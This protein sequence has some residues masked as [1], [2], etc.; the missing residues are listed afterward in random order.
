MA[1]KK[2]ADAGNAGK[3]PITKARP[4]DD[5]FPFHQDF[6]QQLVACLWRVPGAMAQHAEYF[7]P[8]YL[9]SATVRTL[10][11]AMVEHFKKYRQVPTRATL[12]EHIR[13]IHPKKNDDG[14]ERARNALEKKLDD[15]ASEPIDDYDY[16]DARIREFVRYVAVRNVLLDAKDDLIAMKYDPEL[17]KLVR[18]ALITGADQ[19]EA[20]HA[21][22][23]DAE[24]RVHAVT[25]PEHNPRIPTGLP[26]L[27]GLI[28]GG[29]QAGELGVLLALPK[30]F[31]SG[32]MLNFAY[33]GMQ[34]TVGI[35]V[36][37]ITLE[38]SEE[39]VGM[40]FDLR[41]ALKTK[42]EMMADPEGFLSILQQRMDVIVGDN[43]LF[44]KGFKTK[45]CTCDTIRAYLD[46]MYSQLGIKVGMLIVDYLDLLKPTRAR[47][48]TYIEDTDI[49][50][51]LRS[52]A[53]K[54]EYNIPIWTACIQYDQGVITNE[55]RIKIGRIGHRLRSSSA[56]L[57]ALSY[58]HA[59]RRNEWRQVTN[60]F[61]N[62]LNR[63]T[64][65]RIRTDADAP[66]YQL[67]QSRG[68]VVTADH[69]FFTPS[70]EKVAAGALR[71]GDTVMTLGYKLSADQRQVCIGTLLGDG[72]LRRV[73]R[74]LCATHGNRQKY[75]AEWKQRAF[76][77]LD[78]SLQTY[79]AKTGWK[80]VSK[81]GESRTYAPP[82]IC[83]KVEV[84]GA[85]EFTAL[86]DAFYAGGLKRVPR[87]LIDELGPLGLAVW[88]MDDGCIHKRERAQVTLH[89]NGFTDGDCD[90]L[91]EWFRSKWGLSATKSSRRTLI[92]KAASS[93]RLLSIISPFV[94]KNMSARQSKTFTCPVIECGAVTGMPATV[95][96][97]GRV[98]FAGRKAEKR[99]RFDIEVDGNHNYYLASGV[100]VSNCRATREAVGSRRISM[101]HMSKSFERVGVAD[102]VLALCMTEQEKV[103]GKMRI[104]GVAARND[105]MNK[106][107]DC[108][109]N[110]EKMQL[111][112]VG[113][114]DIDF[115]DED[116]PKRKWKDDDGD[117]GGS[118]P[119]S[120]GG[121]SI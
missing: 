57:M 15:L 40:R 81:A 32:T 18:D 62:G 82:R 29:L 92:F 6:Q 13:L 11:T 112:S 90:F 36:A 51:D 117:G 55:G 96:G 60:W 17:P 9:D 74:T 44:I 71:L 73:R 45:T 80:Q 107:V 2:T 118:K 24:A 42:D 14:D 66:A 110:F 34:Q 116:K 12:A 103:E 70:G 106:V 31:K 61:D 114:S 50:E 105:G 63:D 22:V 59:A 87:T 99:K 54:Q 56:P 65:L 85:H 4:T 26:H 120:Y 89:T 39:L 7:K 1:E 98:S 21:W 35:N 33:S 46:R 109:V 119:K 121:D 49:C 108:R 94:Q 37:Y 19:F 75:Y 104:A 84:G 64:F 113:V 79:V 58:N 88:F 25:N 115:E 53:S 102:I 97:V 48:K 91:V 67:R 5:K 47:E 28:G 41:C 16:V 77:G 72:S 76:T 83:H 111:T 95:V 101:R 68:A 3:V 100:L 30:H 10:C 78:V 93:R 8:S 27:D 23:R 20:G 69:H 38:L 52:V 43:E 86:H